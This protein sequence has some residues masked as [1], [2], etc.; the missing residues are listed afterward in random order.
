MQPK[1]AIAIADKGSN[2]SF[3]SLGSGW[4]FFPSSFRFNSDEK[5]APSRAELSG[6]H[7]LYPPR[8]AGQYYGGATRVAVYLEILTLKHGKTGPVVL[9]RK[10]ET[11]RT[12]E[13]SRRLSVALANACGLWLCAVCWC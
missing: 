8:V 5:R 1:C 13:K 11:F 7:D 4:A 2:C 9:V 10:L 3:W 12:Y 6:L